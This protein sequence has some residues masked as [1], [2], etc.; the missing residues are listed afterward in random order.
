MSE[1]HDRRVK[2]T[3][4]FADC[5]FPLEVHCTATTVQE[6]DICVVPCPVCTEKAKEGRV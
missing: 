1:S 5:Y 6:W 2:I 4:R 3:V